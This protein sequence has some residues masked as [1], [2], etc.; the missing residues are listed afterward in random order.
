VSVSAAR[1]H[2]PVGVITEREYELQSRGLHPCLTLFLTTYNILL[3]IC[4][5]MH[6]YALDISSIREYGNL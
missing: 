3:C 6:Y 5:Q 2:N 4:S 1:G